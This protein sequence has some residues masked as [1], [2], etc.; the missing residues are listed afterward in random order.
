MEVYADAIGNT[1]TKDSPWFVVPADHKWFTRI[2]VSNVIINKLESLEMNY[3]VV[4]EDHMKSLLEAKE[5][6]E[7][8]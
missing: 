7:N 5:M 3:P 8:E 4:T 2:V 1:S 6:L